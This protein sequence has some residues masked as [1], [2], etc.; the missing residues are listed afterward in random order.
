MNFVPKVHPV[1][2]QVEQEDPMELVANPVQGDPDV[3]LNC[4]IWEYAAIGCTPTQL[5]AMFHDPEFPVLNQLRQ[6]V[7]DDEIHRRIFELGGSE[8][9]LRVTEE[10]DET[11]EDEPELHDL[12][13]L[14]RG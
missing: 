2:R 1:T 13:V 6:Y 5:E 7:G 4:L 12:H 3:M 9:A 11:I 8:V 14:R 10:I